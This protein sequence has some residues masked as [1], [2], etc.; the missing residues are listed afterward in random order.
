MLNDGG[1]GMIRW[2]QDQRGFARFGLD[3]G[4]PDF[5]AFARSFGAAGHRPASTG[6][7]DATIVR[8]LAEP[9]V[10]LID[11]AVDYSRNHEC[12]DIELPALTRDL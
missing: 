12:L 4:N 10:H 11:V 9:G 8:C 2:K 3:F 6:E 7:L 5:V 1:F